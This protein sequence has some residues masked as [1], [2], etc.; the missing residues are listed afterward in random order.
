MKMI[1][2][3][4]RAQTS[5]GLFFVESIF[6]IYDLICENKFR[7]TKKCSITNKKLHGFKWKTHKTDI[8]HEIKFRESGHFWV[9]Q[10]KKQKKK[11]EKNSENFLSW[12]SI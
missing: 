10:S 8:N 11:K 6:A 7:V 3:T 4:L 5:A 12:S 2:G 1:V 9:L